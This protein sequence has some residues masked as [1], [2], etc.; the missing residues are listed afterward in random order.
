MRAHQVISLA[1][2]LTFGLW[3]RTTL[4]LEDSDKESVRILANDADSDFEAGHY[5]LAREK[6]TRAYG[7]ARVP[8]LAVRAAQVSAQV[9]QRPSSCQITP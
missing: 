1:F 4:A 2:I 7:I 9:L 8:T 6:F 5:E 3:P